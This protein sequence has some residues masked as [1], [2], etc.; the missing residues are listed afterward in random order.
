MPI[1][2]MQRCLSLGVAGEV[3]HLS[4]LPRCALS[5]VARHFV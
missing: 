5:E 3:K 4:D 1:K 2:Q